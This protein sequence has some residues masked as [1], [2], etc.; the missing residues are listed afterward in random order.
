MDCRKHTKMVLKP[1]HGRKTACK[2]SKS[3]MAQVRCST[4]QVTFLGSWSQTLEI[5][6]SIDVPADVEEILGP[7]QTLGKCQLGEASHFGQ[8]LGLRIHL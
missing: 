7:D 5:I 1:K 3:P 8:D 6:N 4:S 2:R